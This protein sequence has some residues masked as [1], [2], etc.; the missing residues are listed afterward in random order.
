MGGH[1]FKETG[2]NGNGTCLKSFWGRGEGVPRGWGWDIGIYC[3]HRVG[4]ESKQQLS[5]KQEYTC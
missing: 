5:E 3:G 2:K 4:F 1:N